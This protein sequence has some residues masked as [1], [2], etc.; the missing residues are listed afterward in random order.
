MG[1]QTSGSLS[2][3]RLKQKCIM[4]LVYCNSLTHFLHMLHSSVL[5]PHTII[6]NTTFKTKT[7]PVSSDFSTKLITQL[8]VQAPGTF[9]YE[10]SHCNCVLP[11]YLKTSF[12]INTISCLLQEVI[13]TTGAVKVHSKHYLMQ[14]YQHQGK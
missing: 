13:F 14:A 10:S 5:Y 1:W 3:S 7:K 11:S 6:S 2:E 4:N 9:K 8:P 12:T